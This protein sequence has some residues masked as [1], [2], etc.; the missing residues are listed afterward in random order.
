MEHWTAGILASVGVHATLVWFALNQPFGP[1][2]IRAFP[3][4]PDRFE[5]IL[6]P[7]TIALA[8]RDTASDSAPVSAV[9]GQATP[10]AATDRV[11]RTA[12][13][14]IGAVLAAVPPSPSRAPT[15]GALLDALTSRTATPN[16][17]TRAAVAAALAAPSLQPSPPTTARP[18]APPSNDG[19]PVPASA[20]LPARD[21][22]A[23]MLP[24][25]PTFASLPA[26]SGAI[27][28]PAPGST[29]VSP[30]T[31]HG[32]AAGPLAATPAA[33]I[34]SG[35]AI[36]LAT[37]RT[38]ATADLLVIA[39][40]AAAAGAQARIA[41]PAVTPAA[42][43]QI[44]AAVPPISTAVAAAP[45][46]DAGTVA[47][48]MAA[49]AIV[50][51][52][53]NT[54]S[55]SR[56]APANATPPAASKAPPQSTLAASPTPPA[57][58]ATPGPDVGVLAAPRA[59]V[60]NANA[61]AIVASLAPGSPWTTLPAA[62]V[63]PSQLALAATPVSPAAIAKTGRDGG[64]VPPRAA[65]AIANPIVFAGLAPDGAMSAGPPAVPAP[66]QGAVAA[67]SAALATAT[68]NPT[69]GSVAAE[70]AALAA[71][72]G[73]TVAAATSPSG[74]ITPSPFAVRPPTPAAAPAP[75]AVG[76]SLSPPSMAIA[77]TP[78]AAARSQS[79]PLRDTVA[80]SPGTASAGT[81]FVAPTAA[82]VAAGVASRAAG[83]PSAL[84]IAKEA[85]AAAAARLDALAVASNRPVAVDASANRPADITAPSRA[86]ATLA[87]QAAGPAARAPDSVQQ[88]A[89]QTATAPPT[90]PSPL[91]RIASLPAL[92]APAPTQSRPAPP[93]AA[94]PSVLTLG[95]GPIV[96][97]VDADVVA[98]DL[99]QA[100]GAGDAAELA[101]I[102]VA[103]DESPLV[104][105]GTVR[106]SDVTPSRAEV[107]AARYRAGVV[108]QIQ[109][110]AAAYA[111]RAQPR[112]T[113]V[114]VL[115]DRA[116]RLVSRSVATSS[117]SA[118]ADWRALNL[119]NRAG[120]FPPF[121]RG[122]GQSTIRI[123]IAINFSV[124]R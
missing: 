111:R 83:P 88:D 45:K 104:T 90:A 62:T 70:E 26:V 86:P 19:S 75:A 39:G 21:R 34:S 49:T 24:A 50:I 71:D 96:S 124:R 107:Q 54:A 31:G 93:V 101:T 115:I 38:D 77:A 10:V 60:A 64:A 123:R 98:E 95:L 57:T 41:P 121:P 76:P 87:M 78:A 106:A 116:G 16:G 15:E 109:R 61:E 122:I 102:L 51:A 46:G 97:A 23:A 94:P 55:T 68:P 35:I 108:G 81:T 117:G 40:T 65:A 8:P 66:V 113:V 6:A 33:K 1:A 99:P 25:L 120:P 14:A 58:D 9:P 48:S 13:P 29:E 73:G 79:T 84:S 28:A 119:V 74:Q 37:P 47:P 7:P 59:T 42:A 105:G 43:L 92:S 44:G 4:G 100:I 114:A 69:V 30:A 85:P 22:T 112:S 118:A 11:G 110:R 72:R 27:A 12:N 80:A 67:L 20:A 63:A 36:A 91:L 103:E 89:R 56:E 17:A 5:A 82:P 2:G 18:V 32:P 53:A 52:E 3:P